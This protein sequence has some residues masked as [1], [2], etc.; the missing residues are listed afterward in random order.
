M[1]AESRSSTRL[2]ALMPGEFGL[3]VTRAAAAGLNRCWWE[4]MTGAGADCVAGRIDTAVTR[5]TAKQ[6]SAMKISDMSLRVIFMKYESCRTLLSTG[7][8]RTPHKQRCKRVV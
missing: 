4:S 7:G 6:P 2:R 1:P 5:E 3:P 8:E